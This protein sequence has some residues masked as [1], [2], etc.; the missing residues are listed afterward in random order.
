MLNKLAQLLLLSATAATA[1]APIGICVNNV[2][3]VI[4]GGVI[5]PVPYAKVYVCPQGTSQ[6]ACLASGGASV[7]LYPTTTLSGATVPN[8][9][10]TDIGGNYFFCAAHGHYALAIQGASGVYFVP[11]IVLADDWANGG[12]VSGTWTANQFNGPL[13]G[14]ANTA[15][16]LD[17]TPTN[18]GAG[19]TEYAYGISA[20]GNALCGTFP[21]PVTL[22]YQT[23]KSAA[24]VLPQ[25]P[26]L[27]FDSAFF[28]VTDGPSLHQTQVS[29]VTAGGAGGTCADPASLTYDTFGRVTA[30][31]S[32]TN[33]PVQELGTGTVSWTSATF[34]S[35]AVTY[36]LQ[37]F[38]L[39]LTPPSGAVVVVMP[40]TPLGDE[41]Q[42]TGW[43]VGSTLYIKVTHGQ[44]NLPYTVPTTTFTWTVMQ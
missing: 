23:V 42:Y 37:S 5:A 8:P 13:N 44:F 38:T 40:Q 17:V 2:A 36:L 12:T 32:A 20:N 14:N 26:N 29:G 21:T 10:T 24:T 39:S 7:T 16:A 18:C 31:T 22:Y 30:C 15:S 1:Q 35:S 4:S 9:F 41:C 43:F 6:T 34:T 33:S 11:D 28:A 27:E 19:G 3:Q 25:E